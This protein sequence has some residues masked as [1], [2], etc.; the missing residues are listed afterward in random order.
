MLINPVSAPS[1]APGNGLN[2][3]ALA[4]LGSRLAN[5]SIMAALHAARCMR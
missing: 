1:G 2:T 3:S 5:A 4:L